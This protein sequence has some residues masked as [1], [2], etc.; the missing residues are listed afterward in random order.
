MIDPRVTQMAEVLVGYSTKVKR[1]DV[2]LIQGIGT[3]TIPFLRELYKQCL[4]KGAKYVEYRISLGDMERDFFMNAGQKQVEYFPQHELDFMKQVDVFIACRAPENTSYLAG[5]DSKKLSAWSR[6][7]MPIQDERVKNTRWVVTRWPTQSMA[8]DAGMSLEVF[9]KFFFDACIFDYAGLKK[10]QVK[11][12]RLMN[13]TN[14]VQIKASDTDLR[15]SMKGLKSESC[16]GD[17]NVPDGE[18]FS[19][20]VKTSVE[21]Y[22]QYNAP[23]NYQGMNFDRIYLEFEK[24]RI[25]KAECPGSSKQLNAI[26]DTDA[27]SRYVGEFAIGTNTQITRPMRNIL[28]DEKIFGSIH[29]TP[30]MAYDGTVADNGNRSAIHWDLV[31]MLVGDGEIIFDGVTIQKDGLFVHK[32]LLD[33]NPPKK[34]KAKGGKKK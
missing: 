24:G 18:V 27:G 4:K 29:F 6:T 9:E 32:D 3:E 12:E 7:F 10:K 26:F 8:Q 23:T 25:V 13:R 17:R 20:P 5:C 11:L 2:V 33:L 28:F 30:G 19:S 16:F 21:G 22:I 1:G 15:F 14:Q 34:A 31:K